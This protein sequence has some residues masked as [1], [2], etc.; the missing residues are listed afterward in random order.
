LKIINVANE[1]QEF[2]IYKLKNYL[3]LSFVK[4]GGL[5]SSLWNGQM[6][7][8]LNVFF[9]FQVFIFK[10]VWNTVDI[11]RYKGRHLK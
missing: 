4:I 1:T 9:S 10:N 8:F 6:V 3:Q 7:S 11:R 5:S 2:I